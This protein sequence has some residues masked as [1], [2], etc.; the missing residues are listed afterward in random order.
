MSCTP[1]VFV[2]EHSYT[3]KELYIL[4]RSREPPP[5]TKEI[6]IDRSTLGRGYLVNPNGTCC[7][8][9]HLCAAYGQPKALL[10]GYRSLNAL[11]HLP[12]GLPEILRPSGRGGRPQGEDSLLTKAIWVVNDDPELIEPV[13]EELLVRLF[14]EAGIGLTFTGETP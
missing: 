9:G 12:A 13:R 4:D 5:R 6:V 3:G 7:A 10:L 1:D 11:P 2:V 8:L 14:A